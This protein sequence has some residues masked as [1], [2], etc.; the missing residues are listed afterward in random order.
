MFKGFKGIHHIALSVNSLE[1]ARLF[2]VEKL[3]FEI[4][5]QDQIPYS[6]TGDCVTALDHAEC[7]M[8][9]VRAGN[10]F[11]EI[12]EFSS[13]EPKPQAF[14]R[15]VCDHG[16][17]HMSFQVEDVHA[18]YRY[19]EEAGVQWHHPPVEAVEGYFMAYGR[20]PFGNVIE[21]QQLIDGQPYS[22]EKLT[23]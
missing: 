10:I 11:L 5:D 4:V 15:S 3:G 16:Y 23:L 9:M 2:Y 6:E 17:T 20:D 7:N 18:A 12:F 8:M 1:Q 14:M 13:P 19:L 22:F 21:V